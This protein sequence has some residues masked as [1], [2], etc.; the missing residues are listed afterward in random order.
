M[1]LMERTERHNVIGN[2][3][4]GVPNWKPFSMQVQDYPSSWSKYGV[5]RSNGSLEIVSYI[6]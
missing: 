5:N 6:L 1:Y 2:S 3:I 4:N